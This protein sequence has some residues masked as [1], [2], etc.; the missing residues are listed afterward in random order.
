VKIG[1]SLTKLI[2][3]AVITLTLTGVL[4]QTIG[5]ITFTKT[6]QYKAV[7]TD[8]AGLL[9]ATDVRIAGVKV[10]EVKKIEIHDQKQA[11]V[12]FTVNREIRIPRTSRVEIKFL[13]LVGG[14]FLTIEE[15]PGSAMLPDKG[16]IP[17]AQTKPA[18][19]LD[20]LLNGF[21]P[22]F[23]AL[24][25]P[26]VNRLAFEIIE[27]LQ[28]EGGTIND[29]LIHTASLTN[30]VA[31]KDQLIG[32]V[33][34]NLNTVL[35]TV[36]ERDNQLDQLIVQLQRLFS[37]LSEDRQAI[38]DSLSGIDLLTGDL[39]GLL[40]DIRPAL[41][42]DVEH[43]GS[44]AAQLNSQ[45][46]DLTKQLKD[47]P[48]RVNAATRTATYGSWFNFFLCKADGEITF[49]PLPT[50]QV[51]LPVQQTLSTPVNVRNTDPV[52]VN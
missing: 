25:P 14:R 51:P 6:S 4:A 15:G 17:I 38:G 39:A 9:A 23:Q 30:T 40:K 43:L 50:P 33:I 42:P 46:G 24:N 1:A 20:V 47:L 29:L 44:V 10:G 35:A 3:F 5:N 2:I 18:L 12:T 31:D 22:L 21:K 13:N 52:C 37:G 48:Q 7:F 45:K 27:T 49:T 36:D 41:K 34:E 28:G 26:D 32:S 8:V 19:D 11:E 16:T